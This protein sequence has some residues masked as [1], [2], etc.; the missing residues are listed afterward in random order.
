MSASRP[1]FITFHCGRPY[2]A[3]KAVELQCRCAAFGV[4]LEVSAAPD[5]GCYWRNTLCKPIFIRARFAA[6]RRNLTATLLLRNPSTAPYA[7]LYHTGDGWTFRDLANEQANN[8]RSDFLHGLAG[9]QDGDYVLFE[10]SRDSLP[11]HYIRGINL[12]GAAP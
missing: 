2:Y 11:L 3:R 10:R 4:P 8:L 7:V 12:P 9:A 1:L 6:M 5:Q